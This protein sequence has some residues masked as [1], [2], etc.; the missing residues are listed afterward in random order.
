MEELALQEAVF[1]VVVPG[2][3]SFTV[4][5]RVWVREEA[6]WCELD[7]HD[8]QSEMEALPLSTVAMDY[9]D[10]KNDLG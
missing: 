1:V 2:R 9:K 4:A 7:E 10:W 3:G 6:D 8:G 5:Q